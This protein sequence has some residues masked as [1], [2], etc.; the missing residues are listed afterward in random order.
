[1]IK[2]SFHQISQ[3]MISYEKLLKDLKSQQ[4]FSKFSHEKIPIEMQYDRAYS[5]SELKNKI[6]I[7]SLDSVSPI[8]SISVFVKCGS[9]NEKESHS[10]TAHFLEHM[11]FKGT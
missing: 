6:K 1:M 7:L 2:K 8:V 9:V 4:H 11:H 10:G 3:K 5:L